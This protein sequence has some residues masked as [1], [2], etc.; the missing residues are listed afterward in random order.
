[1]AKAQARGSTG[2]GVG[3]VVGR[4][5]APSGGVRVRM[6]ACSISKLLSLPSG[7]G[8]VPKPGPPLLAQ[9]VGRNVEIPE[10]DCFD[11]NQSKAVIG[12]ELHIRSL[13][14]LRSIQ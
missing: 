5:A 10:I 8:A 4:A 3:A 7:F 11:S 6:V 13:D 1:M 12:N 9:Y 2:P 14:Y